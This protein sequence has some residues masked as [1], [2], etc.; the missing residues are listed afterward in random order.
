MGGEFCPAEAEHLQ[1]REFESPGL[2]DG[3]NLEQVKS[4]L[5][6]NKERAQKDLLIKWRSQR[7]LGPSI[8]LVLRE[9]VAA[10]LLG[11]SSLG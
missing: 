6:T 10:T 9:V 11:P 1:F 8:T 5:M 2:T 7:Q 3:L 4:D